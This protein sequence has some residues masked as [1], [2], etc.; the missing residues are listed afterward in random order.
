MITEYTIISDDIYMAE[1]LLQ[2]IQEKALINDENVEIKFIESEKTNWKMFRNLSGVVIHYLSSESHLND[3][4]KKLVSISNNKKIKKQIV[5]CD[6][7]HELFILFPAVVKKLIVIDARISKGVLNKVLMSIRDKEKLRKMSSK[8]DAFLGMTTKQKLILVGLSNGLSYEVLARH[9]KISYKTVSSYKRK[10][11]KM[12]GI[13][14]TKDYSR[15][16]TVM[17]DIFQLIAH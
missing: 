15:F 10:T 12:F 1:G 11:M 17:K 14:S 13:V 3:I 2:Q 8:S 5:L 6:D 16:I 9:Y 7:L 4:F